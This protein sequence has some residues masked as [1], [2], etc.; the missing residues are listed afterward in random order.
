MAKVAFELRA[1]AED[2]SAGST[3]LPGGEVYDVGD[4]LKAGNGK[5]TL[6]PDAGERKDEDAQRKEYDRALRDQRIA[7]A[8]DNFEGLKRTTVGDSKPLSEKGGS[9]S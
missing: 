2:F 8:L 4:A 5:I 3:S 1:D 9:G 6:N 7:E